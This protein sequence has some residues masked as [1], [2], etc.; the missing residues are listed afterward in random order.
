MWVC[1]DIGMFSVMFLILF[2]II[3]NVLPAIL[4]V[5]GPCTVFFVE[6]PISKYFYCIVIARVHHCMYKYI[7][8]SC[9]YLWLALVFTIVKTTYHQETSSHSPPSFLRHL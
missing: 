7:L 5:A 1:I 9:N 2:L 4:S 6:P 8:L 3:H